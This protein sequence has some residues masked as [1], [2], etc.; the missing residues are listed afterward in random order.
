MGFL[1]DGGPGVGKNPKPRSGNLASKKAETTAYE[2]AREDVGPFS[3]R[4]LILINL[5]VIES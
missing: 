2:E 4:Q 5:I 3:T 1:E